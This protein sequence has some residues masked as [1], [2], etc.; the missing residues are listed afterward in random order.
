MAE[1]NLPATLDVNA[2]KTRVQDHVVGTFGAL[3]PEDQFKAMVDAAIKQFFDDARDFEYVVTESGYN[4]SRL[5]LQTKITPFQQMVWEIV[6]PIVKTRLDEYMKEGGGNPL[7]EF[8]KEFMGQK[9]F[10]DQQ[11]MGVQRLMIAM[12]ASI[13]AQAG[14]QS[15]LNFKTSLACAL[16]NAG[17]PQISVAVWNAN[18]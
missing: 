12:C 9:D 8:L 11:V 17:Y 16:D 3:I 13:F 18:P 5:K 15:V 2:L 4:H 1:P 6:K 7:D 10:Q 14:E